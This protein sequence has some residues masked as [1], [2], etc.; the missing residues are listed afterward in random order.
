[1]RKFI[2]NTVD[3]S[4][5]DLQYDKAVAALKVLRQECVNYGQGAQFNSQLRYLDQKY[6]HDAIKGGFWKKVGSF[7]LTLVSVEEAN[8]TRATEGL[9]SAEQASEFLGRIRG[10]VT[11]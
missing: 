2:E 7:G 1:M 8:V 4:P 3:T 10:E 9:V 5:G 11:E 6:A